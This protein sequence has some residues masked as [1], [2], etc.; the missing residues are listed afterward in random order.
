MEPD[1]S[2]GSEAGSS[3]ETGAFTTES[4]GGSPS[5]LAGEQQQLTRTRIRKAAME[6]VARRG[7]DATVQEIADLS[8]V[9]PRTIFRHYVSHDRLIAA[10]V[11]DMF[12]ACGRYPIEGLPGVVDDLEGYLEGLPRTVDDLDSWLESLTATIHARTARIFGEAFW[13]I[14]APIDKGSEALSEVARLRRQYRLRGVGFLAALAWRTA[15][16]TGEPPLDLVLAFALN[17]SAFTTQALMIDFDQ[18]PAQVGA[19]TCDIL[20][21]FVK[22]TVQAQRAGG[23]DDGAA[24]RA[25]GAGV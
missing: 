16:G 20:K 21:A 23:G 3:S 12:E 14:H 22:R 6:V 15:G 17:L 10:T 9:S 2:G 4:E 25:E 1:G 13:D 8:G 5:G 11:K 7:F 18:T 19:L 24:S